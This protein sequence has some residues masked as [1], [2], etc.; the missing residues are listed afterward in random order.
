MHRIV[1]IICFI[2]LVSFTFAFG[3]ISKETILEKAPQL[4]KSLETVSD[5]VSIADVKEM[6]NLYEIILN[7]RGQKRIVYLT[8][9]FKYMILGNLFDRDNKNITQERIKEL[10]KINISS[11]PLNDAIVY[12]NGN[13]SKKLIA[14]VDPFCGHCKNFVEYLKKQNDYTLYMFIFPLSDNSKEAAVKILC[15]K[16]P[17]EAYQKVN[18]LKDTCEDGKKKLEEHIKISRSFNLMGTPFI[19]LEDG[20]NFFGFDRAQLDKYFSK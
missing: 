20:S 18:E 8:K 3:E 11:I 7:V 16:N 10:N 2:L 12:K 13:G 14:F 19:I 5:S 6:D 17:Y 9:D 4:K 1:G 15:S